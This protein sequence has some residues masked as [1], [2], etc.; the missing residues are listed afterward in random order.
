MATVGSGKYTYEVIENWG[1][2]PEGWIL[3]QTAIVTDS[4]DRVYLSI[5]RALAT[6]VCR[7][8]GSAFSGD[9]AIAGRG[10]TNQENRRR[11]MIG[12][13]PPTCH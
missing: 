6:S 8:W 5:S 10:S 3:G 7:S 1:K 11:S 9:R 13:I 2:L 4:E 12:S